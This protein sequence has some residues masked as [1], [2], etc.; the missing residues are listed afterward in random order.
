MRPS[1]NITDQTWD[2][3]IAGGGHAGIEAALAAARMGCRSLLVTMEPEAIGRMSC[4]PAIGGL[5][6]GH[7]V[8]EIDALGGEMGLVADQTGLQYKTLNK[9][10]GRAV[11]SPRAQIDKRAYA[12][13][14]KTI[15][16]GEKNLTLIR[17]EITE[18]A[19]KGADLEGVI[20]NHDRRLLTRAAI[21][22]CGTFLNGLIHI[23]ERK[24]NA[25]RLGERPSQG[26]TEALTAI[27]FRSGRLKTGTC[28]RLRHDSI[29]WEQTKATWG[30]NEPT[31]FSFRTPL[32][33]K[34]ANIPCHITHTGP[35]VHDVIRANL[36]RSPLYA[37]EIEG[38]GPRYCPSIEDKVVRFAS[39][40]QH[41]LF[42]EP[43]WAGSDQIYV[44]GFSTSLPEEVQLEALRGVPG[45]EKAIFVRP[46]YAIE[47]D[48]F[49]P[50]QLRATLESKDVAGLYLAGQI[51]GTSGY[52]EAAGQGLLAG[53]NAAARIKG[54]EQMVLRRDTSYLG[55]LVDDL[56]TKDADEPYRMFTSRAEYRL[57]LRPDNTDLRLGHLGIRYGLL[58]DGAA[59]RLEVRRRNIAAF[60]DFCQQT[61]VAVARNQNRAGKNDNPA[62][63]TRIALADLLRRPEVTL[64]E[65]R[66][67]MPPALNDLPTA[68]LFTAETDIRYAGYLERQHAL[69]RSMIRLDET[70]IDP[71]FEIAAITAMRREAREKLSRVRPETLGQAARIAGVNPPDIALLSIHLKR[72]RVSRGTPP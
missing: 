29:D 21:L 62:V 40:E 31:P 60:K 14:M 2:V 63:Q 72:W 9:S 58:S 61:R 57:L 65:V 55:V 7:L 11:W 64:E 17:G 37:G 45:L 32:P 6:K 33:F 69:A 35:E 67:Y 34:P 70:R 1:G 56:I 44:N 68:D 36:D 4:N 66:P 12:E 20:L 42:L 16:G 18:V 13:R 19:L 47:Y 71:E 50:R 22:T 8:R 39:R 38:V 26:I 49:P 43:E 48:F 46:G 51:N 53:I 52:E 30:D 54:L 59:K 28:P 41:Q 23:G 15:I 5:A 25:G 24:Y 27:G 10:K 3:V